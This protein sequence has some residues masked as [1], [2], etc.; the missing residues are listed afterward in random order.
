MDNSE[1]IILDL[2]GGTG[3]WSKPY[4]DVG[5]DVRVITLP[6]DDIRTYK[7]PK[8]VYGILAAPPCKE[9]S[10]ANWRKNR[11]ERN[12]ESG[13]ECVEACLNTIWKV[14]KNKAPLKF[15]AIENPVGYLYLFLGRP[16]YKFQPWQF[17]EIGMLAAKRTAL[18]GYFAMPQPT[19]KNRPLLFV[20]YIKEK[21]IHKWYGASAKERAITPPGFA[22]AF[23]KANQ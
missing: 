9:F 11:H 4:K 16:P 3:A 18:W 1:K 23:F 7:P 19:I 17:G 6:E 8:S 21:T 22:K 12:Y 20:P 10:R 13:M 2:C 5:Y 14:Q 15:W